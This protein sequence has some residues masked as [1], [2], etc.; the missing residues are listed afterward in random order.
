MSSLS[1]RLT[2]GPHVDV[3]QVEYGYLGHYLRVARGSRT[4]VPGSCCAW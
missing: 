2:R 4:A 1:E 3:L